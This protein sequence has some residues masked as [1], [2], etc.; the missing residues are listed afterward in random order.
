[1]RIVGGRWRGRRL[2]KPGADVRPTTDRL[3][4][5]LFNVLADSVADSIWV[6]AFAGSGAVGIEAL[7]RGAAW[8]VFNDKSARALG[9]VQRNLQLCGAAEGFE[10]QQKDALSLFNHLRGRRIDFVFLDPPY[11]YGR[12]A[13]LLRKIAEALPQHGPTLI[14]EVFKKTSLDFLEP[15]WTLFKTVRA[16][17]S[18][19]LFLRRSG[20]ER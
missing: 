2:A 17:D 9:L 15:D 11:A 8:V 7:S 19:L 6:D 12:Y 18:H 5:A 20:A 4:E 16:G 10:I 3:R 13:E 14:L 1:M